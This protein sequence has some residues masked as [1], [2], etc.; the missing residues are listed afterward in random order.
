M[1]LKHSVS[2]SGERLFRFASLTLA[3]ISVLLASCGGGG[4]GGYTPPPPPPPATYTAKSGVAQKGPLIKGSTVTAQELDASLSPTGK[5]YSYQTDSN[6]GTFSP[7]STFGS[8]YIGVLATGYYFDEVANAVST[9]TVTLNGYSDLTVDSVL[10]VNLL[11]TL[12]YQRIQN[13]IT[14]SG[15]T[16]AAAR[17]QAE[18]EVLA[19]LSIPAGSYGSFSSLDLSGST[20][21]DH[22]LAAIS[23]IFVYGNAPGPLSQLIA[24]FQ[25]DI[26]TN[27]AITNPATKAALVAAAKAVNPTAVAANLTADYASDG[28]TFTASNISDWIS[29][30]G[31]GVIGKFAFQVAD[32]TPS[33]VFSFP[34]TVVTQFAGTSVSVTSCQLSVNGTVVSGTVSFN[35][36]DAVTLS[37][38]AGDFPNGVLNCYLVSGTTKLVR[39]SFVSG[40]VSISVTPDM[41]SVPMGLTQQFTATGTFSDTS[42]ANLTTSVRWTTDTPAVATV[43]SIGIATTV[44]TGSAVITATSGSVSASTT[45]TVTPVALESIAITPN[46]ISTGVDVNVRLKA[47]GTYSDGTTQDVTSAANWTSDTTSVSTIGPTTGIATGAA[48]GSATISA[49]VG[50]V[51]GSAPLSVSS[52]A[53]FPS[54]RMSAFRNRHTATLLSNGTALVAGGYTES[55]GSPSLSSAEIFDPV[56]QS[57][58]LTGSMS[59][60]RGAHTATLLPNGAVLV[61]GGFSSIGP[62]NGTAEI[63]DPVAGTWSATGSMSTPRGSHTATL[64][65]NGTILI[66]GGASQDYGSG[67]AALA[68]AEIYDPSSGTWTPTGSMTTARY[69]HTATLLPNGTVLVA[70]GAPVVPNGTGGGGLP[71]ATAEI[72]DP[73]TGTW[74]STGSMSTARGN[75]TATLLPNGMVLVAGGGVE[76]SDMNDTVA[77]AEIYDPAGRTW[78][79]TASMATARAWHTATLLPNGTVLVAGGGDP[80]GNVSYTSTE[81]YDPLAGTWALTGNLLL[82][83][84]RHTATLLLN[85]LVLAAGGT[86][87]VVGGGDGAELYD[88]LQ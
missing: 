55:T 85:G 8:Q 25:S 17:T 73:S 68:G 44:S 13:L 86:N 56:A 28:V 84:D 37:P 82:A 2:R 72:Y 7:T 76:T 49:T 79:A 14:K 40:L 38:S 57:W 65:P 62:V 26:G 4:G 12:E 64:L 19:A 75:H 70:G 53:W 27:G 81:I 18:G 21:G 31:D 88:D 46:P 71:V 43:A 10:N 51:S 9:G 87:P 15:L 5:Q 1:H 69:L 36:G 47:T 22:I 3:S 39:A 63:Y 29:Q 58:A 83:R 23:S 6:L 16:F 41:P 30:A 50:P 80:D 78:S 61:A 74:S 11:T 52:N 35:A 42:T 33:S 77:S 66:A 67:L 60:I 34:S 54:G 20:D 59:T 45:L 32:A 48:T 24:N